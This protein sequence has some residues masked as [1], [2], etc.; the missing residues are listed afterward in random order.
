M[1]VSFPLLLE[2][3][4]VT[5]D[6]PCCS[7]LILFVQDLLNEN[8]SLNPGLASEKPEHAVE[9]VRQG[10]AVQRCGS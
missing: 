1:T 2:P 5:H 10:V 3:Q 7:V 4:T 9:Q 6:L 8:Q